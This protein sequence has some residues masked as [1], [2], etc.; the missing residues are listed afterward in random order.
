[1]LPFDV[2]LQIAK[3]SNNWN[4]TH[5][6]SLQ[7]KELQRELQGELERRLNILLKKMIDDYTY[8]TT[9]LPIERKMKRGYW[10]GEMIGTTTQALRWMPNQYARSWRGCLITV[11]DANGSVE[12]SVSRCPQNMFPQMAHAFIKYLR[13]L[14]KRVRISKV[15]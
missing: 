3:A 11:R 7:S 4:T 6:I 15:F 12:I 13:S 14:N 1:M 2:L 5:K 8:I 9:H 10:R